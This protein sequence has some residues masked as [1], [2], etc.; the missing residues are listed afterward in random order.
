MVRTV[1]FP[2]YSGRFRMAKPAPTANLLPDLPTDG[3]AA[4]RQIAQAIRDAVRGGIMRQAQPLPPCTTIASRYGVNKDTVLAAMRLLDAEK[5][6]R[7]VY[8]Q[9][10]YVTGYQKHDDEREAPT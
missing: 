6:V 2:H 10:Y 5:V 4:Y 3:Q 8:G 1:T 7:R 9:G